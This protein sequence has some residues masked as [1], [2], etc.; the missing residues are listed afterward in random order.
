MA[1]ANR[2]NKPNFEAALTELEALVL[3]MEQGDI[4]LEESLR[5]YEQ[6]VKLSQI[7]QEALHSAEQKVKI[8]Q[9]K[10]KQ[11]QDQLSEFSNEK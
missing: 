8:L 4:S 11:A 9:E 2:R 3:R 5:L 7:C 10:E 6:G 1:I